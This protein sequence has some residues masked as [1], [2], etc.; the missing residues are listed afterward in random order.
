MRIEFF[1]LPRSLGGVFT[2]PIRVPAVF[3]VIGALPHERSMGVLVGLGARGT[4]WEPHYPGEAWFCHSWTWR[5]WSYEEWLDFG[6]W[7]L[8]PIR[9]YRGAF[10]EGFSL[11][12]GWGYR[13]QGRMVR[14]PDVQ[15]R[16]RV[17]L[18]AVRDWVEDA[19][20]RSWDR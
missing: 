14:W 1:H 20:R 11:F 3:V 16:W 2:T 8:S 9:P 5:W 4:V 12:S 19:L 18:V 17:V 6:W 10:K 7:T 13:K 15:Y